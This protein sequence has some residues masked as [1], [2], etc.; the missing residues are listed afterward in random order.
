MMNHPL[1]VCAGL[2]AGLAA[3]SCSTTDAPA[4]GTDEAEVTSSR[5]FRRGTFGAVPALLA[6]GGRRRG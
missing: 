1:A 4:L 3:A 6:P 2:L 5:V